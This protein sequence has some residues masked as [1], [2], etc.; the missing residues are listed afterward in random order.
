M[1]DV[2]TH[3][4]SPLIMI[5]T[6]DEHLLTLTSAT[7]AAEGYR[8]VIATDETKALAVCRKHLPDLIVLDLDLPGGDGYET[9]RR[10]RAEAGV[11]HVPVIILVD[12]PAVGERALTAGATHVLPRRMEPELLGRSVNHLLDRAGAAQEVS[13]TQQV[14]ERL[15]LLKEAIDSLPIGITITSTDGKIIYANPA[16]AEMHGLTLEELLSREA[17]QFAPSRLHR[18]LSTEDMHGLGVWRRESVNVRTDGEEFPVQLSSMAVRGG[19]GA[20]LGIVTTCEDISPRKEAEQRIQRLAYYDPLTGLPNRRMFL[21][22]LH[23]ALALA[24]REKHR[25]GLLFLDLDNFKDTNDTKGHDFGDCLLREVAG[26]LGSCMRDCD[27]LARLGGDEFVVLLTSIASQ[28]SAAIAARRILAMFASPF[29]IG[30][31]RV[32]SGASIGIALYPDDGDGFDQ[33]LRCADVA[34]YRAKER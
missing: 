29:D 9:C 11:G 18:E 1:T 5:A 33:L 12:D 13:G 14:L 34:M 21:D 22:R 6:V 8:T 3:K 25:V 26:R 30:K 32:F 20:C 28:E 31:S 24:Q 4:P 19:G 27:T 17:R 2:V 10:L 16:E 15:Q 23:Q 7:L